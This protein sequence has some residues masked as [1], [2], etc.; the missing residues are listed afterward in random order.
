MKEGE[1]DDEDEGNWEEYSGEEEE[2]APELVLVSPHG[3][4]SSK[5]TKKNLKVKVVED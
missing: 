5:K 4:K 2:E 1:D 3:D